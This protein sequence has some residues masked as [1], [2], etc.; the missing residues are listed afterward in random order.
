MKRLLLISALFFSLV[1]R[2][3]DGNPLPSRGSVRIPVIVLEFSD[4]KLSLDDPAGHFS[5]MLGEKGYSEYGATGSVKDYFL[6]NSHGFFNPE[7]DVYG[8]VTLDKKMSAYGK[9]IMKNGV[10]VDDTAPEKA[11]LDACKLLDETVDFSVYDNDGDGIID[12]CIFYFAGYDQA[13]GGPA[14]AIWSHHWD[15]GEDVVEDSVFDGVRVG[16]YFCASELKDG[17]GSQPTGI[18]SSCHELAHALGLPDFYDVNGASDGL[19]GG[20]YGFSLMGNGLYNNGGRTPPYLNAVELELLGWMEEIPLIEEGEVILRPIYEGGAYRIPTATEGEYFVIESRDGSGWD[21]PLPAGLVI[22]HADRSSREVGGTKA[23]ILWDNWRESNAINNI[24]S[25]PCFYLIPSSDPSS[26]NYPS[27]FNPSS[28][29]FPGTSGRLWYDPL[30]W[31]GQHGTFQITNIRLS[32]HEALFTVLKDAGANVNGTVVSSE[33]KTLSGVTVS[34]SGAKSVNTN[35]AGF[36]TFPTEENAG[37]LELTFSKSGYDTVNETFTI[38]EGERSVCRVV[39]LHTPGEAKSELLMKYDPSMTSGYYPSADVIGAVRFSAAELSSLA[40]RQIRTIDCYPF[41]SSAEG[42]GKM[43]VTV[44][45]GPVRVLSLKV[46]NPNLG[47]FK[48]VSIDISDENI[49]IPEGLDIYVGYGFSGAGENSPI[50]V[51]YPGEK[52]NSW[53][54]PF[55]LE[56]STW[57]EMYSATL[58]KHMDVMLS[59]TAKEAPANSLPEMGYTC[60]DTGKGSYSAGEMYTPALILP[61]GIEADGVEWKWDGSRLTTMPFR[62]MAGDHLLE[63]LV[64]YRDGRQEKL[65]LTLKVN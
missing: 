18:G 64:N 17:K 24:G 37:A 57:M 21:A 15:A 19:A 55:S 6:E 65:S 54:S 38:P 43:Y 58:G 28:L 25:H 42:V 30:D 10:R 20:L 44:D 9:D 2:A 48:L 5:K 47:E 12:L 1:A 35:A 33:G 45:F 49:R 46:E 62:L 11:L 59:T 34:A 29:V 13:E 39:V 52:G 7:F 32:G 16:P 26:L 41:I 61:P 51:V 50:G 60:I 63:A 8:P 31:E 53:W 4:V 14:D 40:G 3:G 56:Q 36:F 23:F 27:A 22:Y